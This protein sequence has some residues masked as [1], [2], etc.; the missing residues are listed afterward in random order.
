MVAAP[1]LH[2]SGRAQQAR[3]TLPGRRA[4][5]GRVHWH[6]F[7]TGCTHQMSRKI[8]DS[9]SPISATPARIRERWPDH[10]AVAIRPRLETKATCLWLK[11]SAE[12]GSE[13]PSVSRHLARDGA[14]HA[15]AQRSLEKSKPDVSGHCRCDGST[16]GSIMTMDLSGI[17]SLIDDGVDDDH[18]GRE[19]IQRTRARSA[20]DSDRKRPAAK[21]D[22][23]HFRNP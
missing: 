8:P 2:A 4:G 1:A 12:A 23:N 21:C 15:S 17:G 11:G 3:P 9:R 5:T 16:V 6:S 19:R 20:Q 10:P 13:Q 7:D 22:R 14:S 18:R